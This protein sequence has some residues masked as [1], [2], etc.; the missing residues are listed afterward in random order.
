LV[1]GERAPP[2][3]GHEDQYHAHNQHKRQQDE[4]HNQAPAH[5]FLL[6]H[7]GQAWG[8]RLLRNRRGDRLVS[9][10]GGG[11][12]GVEGGLGFGRAHAQR[13]GG[14][15]FHFKA[16]D[17]IFRQGNQVAVFKL[18]GAGDAHAVQEGA[19]GGTKVFKIDRI[20]AA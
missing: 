18:L 8:N 16:H 7:R 2:G 9:G 14:S 10:L 11:F 17:R 20:T 3:G 4:Q 1:E 13:L 15:A 5:A 19:V 6:A 12:G